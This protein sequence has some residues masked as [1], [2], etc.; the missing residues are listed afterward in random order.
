MGLYSKVLGKGG[1]L[2]LIFMPA[3][4]T[5]TFPLLPFLTGLISIDLRIGSLALMT[6]TDSLAASWPVLPF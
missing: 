3:Y 5:T 1:G 2:C 4:V 6:T